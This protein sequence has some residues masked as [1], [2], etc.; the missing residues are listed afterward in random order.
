MRLLAHCSR[1]AAGATAVALRS[2]PHAACDA[3]LALALGAGS[4][5]LLVSVIRLRGDNPYLMLEED[6]PGGGDDGGITTEL[7]VMSP[8][9]RGGAVDADESPRSMK[10]FELSEAD[11]QP[12]R[13]AA[14]VANGQQ[15]PPRHPQPDPAAE[16]DKVKMLK[17]IPKSDEAS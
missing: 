5:E 7:G 10:N 14:A 15:P 11:E 9:E 16:G 4:Y 6:G 2:R 3:C 12:G 1:A 8:G 13:S 17:G